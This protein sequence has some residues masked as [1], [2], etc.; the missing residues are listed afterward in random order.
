MEVM[1]TI[2]KSGNKRE[3]L[4]LKWLSEMGMFHKKWWIFYLFPVVFTDISFLLWHGTERGTLLLKQK[5][6]RP[7]HYQF[8][9]KHFQSITLYCYSITQSGNFEL[10]IN[11]FLT[12][13]LVYSATYS[14]RASFHSLMWFMLLVAGAGPRQMFHPCEPTGVIFL[15]CLAACV[16]AKLFSEQCAGVRHSLINAI[17]PRAEATMR[18]SS[19]H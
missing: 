4:P 8:K 17:I 2:R 18:M 9:V 13:Q 12:S 19:V 6:Y 14:P 16:S 10:L 3:P 11:F 5:G 15:T 1:K 7:W